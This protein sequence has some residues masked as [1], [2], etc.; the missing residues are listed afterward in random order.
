[1]GQNKWQFHPLGTYGLT[2]NIYLEQCNNSFYDKKKAIVH[3]ILLS[4]LWFTKLPWTHDFNTSYEGK[5]ISDTRNI[6][7]WQFCTQRR[8]KNSIITQNFGS[9]MNM[10]WPIKKT[11]IKKLAMF[12]EKHIVGVSFLWKIQA[13]SSISRVMMVNL[14]P[15][16]A[17]RILSSHKIAEKYNEQEVFYKKAVNKNFAIFTEKHLYCCLFFNKNKGLQLCNFIKKR[18]HKGVFLWILRNF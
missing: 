13:F 9:I 2:K 15:K 18:L 17:Q 10:R 6:Q 16:E 4:K 12:P 5:Q 7:K 11:V 1:M 14:T 3:Q 8:P